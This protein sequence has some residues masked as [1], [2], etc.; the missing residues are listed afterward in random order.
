MLPETQV[1]CSAGN[2]FIGN[3]ELQVPF[4]N[5]IYEYKRILK[6]GHPA[7]NTEISIELAT[8][9]FF[10]GYMRQQPACRAWREL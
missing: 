5:T 2:V 8:H 9:T 6:P 10:Y 7:Y 3:L 4:L 1:D